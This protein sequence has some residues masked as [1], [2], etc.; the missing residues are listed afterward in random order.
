M[1][2]GRR[3]WFLGFRVTRKKL[4][5]NWFGCSMRMTSTLPK[6][7]T[8]DLVYHE[9]LSKKR[10]LSGASGDKRGQGYVEA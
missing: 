3:P 5:F 10:K 2:W 1:L 8:S 4:P 6:K 7:T 9:F